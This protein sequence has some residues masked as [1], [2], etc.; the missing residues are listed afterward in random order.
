VKRRQTV[1]RVISRPGS[2][3]FWSRFERSL[4][5]HFGQHIHGCP[6]KPGI[7]TGMMNSAVPLEE[8][9]FCKGL[10]AFRLK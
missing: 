7:K 10:A 6:N 1:S 9:P 8:N 2:S 3:V 4:N 5:M